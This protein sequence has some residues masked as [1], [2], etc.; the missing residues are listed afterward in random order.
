M[1]ALL[2][3]TLALAAVN[4]VPQHRPAALGAGPGILGAN[5]VH[6]YIHKLFTYLFAYLCKFMLNISS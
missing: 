1:I 6:I 5:T 4:A 3:A 2:F